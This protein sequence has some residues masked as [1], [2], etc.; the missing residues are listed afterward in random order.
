M[1]Q[2]AAIDS[3]GWNKAQAIM[4]QLDGSGWKML[5]TPS[6]YSVN[7]ILTSGE[8]SVELNWQADGKLWSTRRLRTAKR[9][10]RSFSVAYALRFI[11]TNR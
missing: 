8:N 2:Q 10:I 7:L 5:L 9:D 11:A 4:T 6:R 3:K 1:N